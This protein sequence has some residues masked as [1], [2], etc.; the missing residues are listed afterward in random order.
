MKQKCKYF[1]RRCLHKPYSK[2]RRVRLKQLKRHVQFIL[3]VTEDLIN[4]KFVP[5][6]DFLMSHR[7]EN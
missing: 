7:K 4:H 3:N 6:G 5:L 2:R 1:S